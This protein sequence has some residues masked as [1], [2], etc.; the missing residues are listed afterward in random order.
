MCLADQITLAT[1]GKI[2]PLEMGLS[3]V[4]Y[5]FGDRYFVDAC[6]A[7][8]FYIDL[9]ATTIWYHLRFFHSCRLHKQV[10][11]HLFEYLSLFAIAFI[12]ATIFPGYSEVL[13]VG[14]AVA[15]RD[16]FTIWAVASVGNTLGSAVNWL[17]GRYVLHFQDRKWFPFKEEN[18][19]RSQAW[20]QKYGVWTLLLAW[21]PVGGDALTFI[22]GI[23]RVN[24]FIFLLLIF[25]GKAARYALLL[26][27]WEQLSVFFS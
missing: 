6:D 11:E 25:V 19:A 23:M 17:I 20:F 9:C 10:T 3:L 14:M 22:A 2:K 4:A 24:F 7:R 13:V 21:A 26:G 8:W 1:V 27:A 15:G 5:C 12:A 16:P 18:I